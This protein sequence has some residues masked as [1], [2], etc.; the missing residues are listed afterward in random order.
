M[1]SIF[2]PTPLIRLRSSALPPRAPVS[3]SGSVSS[4]EVSGRGEIEARLGA[5]LG[6]FGSRRL[7][8]LRRLRTR[9]ARSRGFRQL[10]LRLGLGL[11]LGEIGRLAGPRGRRLRRRAGGLGSSRDAVIVAAAAIDRGAGKGMRSR[12]RALDHMRQRIAAAGLVGQ[13]GQRGRAAFRRTEAPVVLRARGHFAPGGNVVDELFQALRRQVL[14]GVLEDLHHGRV[15]AGTEALDLFPREVAVGRQLVRMGRDLRLADPDQVFRAAQLARRRAADLDMRLLADRG[16]LEHRVEGRDL[17]H[18]DVR[19][20]EHFGD[21]ADRR[22]RAASPR[23][24]PAP[25]TEA[26]SPRRP[27]GRPGSAR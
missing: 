26:G 8:S 25:A 11:G 5:F 20:A 9:V 1:P 17:E 14:V 13:A 15:D 10:G 18:A 22:A 24:V 23:A 21:I 3:S 27:D 7:C 2:G 12:F 16:Q 4:A 6:P 19:H